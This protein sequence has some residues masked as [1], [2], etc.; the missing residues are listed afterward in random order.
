MINEWI[1]LNKTNKINYFKTKLNK[2]ICNSL[3]NERN[4]DFND[5]MELFKNHPEDE[6]KLKNVI[7]LCIITNK[8]NTKYFEI[9]IIRDNGEIE[10][11]SYRSCISERHDRYNLYSA[12]RYTIESQIKEFRDNSEL[13]CE[14]CNSTNDIHIDHIILFKTIVEQFLKNYKIIPNSFDDNEYNGCKFKDEDKQFMT[15]WFNYHKLNAKLRC[16]CS[17]CNLTRKKCN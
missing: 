14:L 6:S 17:K 10:D 8:R 7:D 2:G 5:F 1:N 15:E 13:K 3:K 4:E 9:N 16:L 12:L 11:I